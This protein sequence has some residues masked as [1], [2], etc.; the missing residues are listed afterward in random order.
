MLPDAL[1]VIF[2]PHVGELDV[3][4]GAV[5]LAGLSPSRGA[6]DLSFHAVATQDGIRHQVALPDDAGRAR[7][8]LQAAVPG[9]TLVAAAPGQ[10]PLPAPSFVWRLWQ[11]SGRRPFASERGETTSRAILTALSVPLATGE[12]VGVHFR[13]GPVRRPRVVG[14]KP[15]TVLSESWPRALALAAVQTPG[16]LDSEARASLRRKLELPGWRLVGFVTATTADRHRA[17]RL[18][19]GLLAALRVAEAPGVQLGVRRSSAR[20]LRRSPLRWNLFLNAAELPGLLGWPIADAG[21][22][23]LGL[24]Q[25]RSVLLP[26]PA[27]VPRTGRILGTAATAPDRPVALGRVESH[28]HLWCIGP[29][30]TGKSTLLAWLIMQD[31]NS[32]ASVVA[33][34]PKGGLVDEVLARYP[35][36]RVD[37]LVVLS[38]RDA[39]P[40]GFN[41]LAAPLQPALVADQLLGVF[42]KL[43]ADSWGPRTAD[44]LQAALLTLAQAPG[45]SL[46]LLPLLLTNAAYRRG[47]V[48]GLN[49]P[50]GLGPFWSWYDGLSDAERQQVIAPSLNKVRPF[51]VR[52][53]LRSVIGQAEPKFNLADVFTKPRVLLIDLAKG[54]LGPEA[55]SLLGTLLLNQ[56][57]QTALSRGVHAASRPVYVIADEVQDFLKLPGDIG[58]LLAQARGLRVGF[59][60]AHQHLGQLPR[61]LQAAV[62]ANARSRVLFQLAEQ[63]AA[64][65]GRGRTELTPSDLS[66]LG[67]Y[68]IYASLQAGGSVTPYF[69]AQTLPLP[70]PTSD[71]RALRQA[72]AERYGRPRQEIEDELRALVQPASPEPGSVGRRPR[73]QP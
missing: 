14:A 57:W 20:A 38:P 67:P 61:D 50:L 4:A 2:P 41:P 17:Q 10:T 23:V 47:L 18:A 24:Q 28:S 39:R 70:E 56:L 15:Q 42:S 26:V 31:I 51:L 65:F 5:A 43:Y 73:R 29:T 8:Q 48:G 68:E 35:A 33:F 21:R 34:D 59:T 63:D 30:G 45:T 40:V 46:A 25:R 16:E 52:A 44:V 71:P 66:G 7:R 72:S 19:A 55:A 64:V 1:D 58:D 12:A 22:G 62:Q 36:E 13:I 69:S 53:D 60:L 6:A 9:L 37:D 27:A 11:S 3:Q 32:G 54:S 49:D